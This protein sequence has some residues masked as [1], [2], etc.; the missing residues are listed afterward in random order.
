MGAKI[1]NL[2]NKFQSSKFG[3]FW[4]KAR[5]Q[6]LLMVALLFAVK[7]ILYFPIAALGES[8]LMRPPVMFHMEVDQWIPFVPEMYIF[9]ISYYIL[10]I[11]FLWILSFYDKKK[12]VTIVLAT[13]CVVVVANICYL[14]Q[15]VKM[16]RVAF[17]NQAA[18]YADIKSVDSIRAFFLWCLD[19]QYKA[20]E[21]ALNCFPSLHATFATLLIIAGLYTGNDE[22]SCPIWWR[23]IFIFFGVGIFL[24]TVFV[25]QHYFVDIVFAL[26]LE[27]FFYFL[28]KLLFVP[29][30]L[31][32]R[33]AKLALK[34]EA[35]ESE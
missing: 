7:A 11:I 14:I 8:G 19:K 12:V 29:L 1:D 6:Y 23:I 18:V 20:D 30:F 13:A 24:S 3:A 26:G 27:V 2:R 34:E 35:K 4:I 9:Y 28:F 10:P 21:T 31:K 32:R 22:K 5:L 16:D 33:E 17:E 25:K 15:Q